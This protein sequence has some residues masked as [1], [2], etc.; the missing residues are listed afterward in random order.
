MPLEEQ[1][2]EE[3]F[4][5]SL[6]S[7]LEIDVI[8]YIAD[9]RVPDYVVIQLAKTLYSGSQVYISEDE[10]FHDTNASLHSKTSSDLSLST[11]VDDPINST[12]YS[13]ALPRE[14]FSYWCFDLLVLICSDTIPG[15]LITH[16]RYL[17]LMQGLPDEE[18][19]RRR[20]AAL[21]L[22]VLLQRCRTTLSSY[23]ADDAVRGNY[24]LPRFG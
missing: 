23:L 15:K 4:D 19:L 17:P 21:S 16:Q 13:K 24:P 22:P 3:L 12:L 11:K 2:A 1:E 9:S 6:L 18:I 5:L 14:R 7:A 8:P 10:S 20:L